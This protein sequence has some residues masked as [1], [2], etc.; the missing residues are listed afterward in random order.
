MADQHVQWSA[1]SCIVMAA[2][3]ARLISDGLRSTLSRKGGRAPCGQSSSSVGTDPV[4]PTTTIFAP[5]ADT[6]P[7]ISASSVGYEA[8][9][10][11]SLPA[12]HK[13]QLSISSRPAGD[14]IAGQ[15]IAGNRLLMSRTSFSASASSPFVSVLTLTPSCGTIRKLMDALG[16]LRSLEVSDI[17]LKTANHFA[18]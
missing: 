5:S 6:G 14:G 3:T 11:K 1:E 9:L 18:K 4:S 8:D 2:G 16:G 7:P 17:I 10:P 12:A 13:A 15:A